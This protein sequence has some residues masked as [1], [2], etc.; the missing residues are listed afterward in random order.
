MSPLI[1]STVMELLGYILRYAH[2]HDSS[3]LANDVNRE[4]SMHSEAF[5][6]SVIHDAQTMFPDRS[7]KPPYLIS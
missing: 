5:F 1:V 2:F 3:T 6:V 4:Y 7:K